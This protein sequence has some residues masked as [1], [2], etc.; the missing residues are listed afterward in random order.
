LHHGRL[1]TP[2]GDAVASEA[3][4]AALKHVSSVHCKPV[5]VSMGGGYS[6][7]LVDIIEAH[8]NTFRMAQTV[9]F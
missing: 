2:G 4:R 5:V 6:P 3:M 7:R 8:V 9:F 1:S